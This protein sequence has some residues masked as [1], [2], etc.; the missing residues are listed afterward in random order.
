MRGLL[1]WNIFRRSVIPIGS[2]AGLLSTTC[3][4][5]EYKVG[6][7]NVRFW[8]LSRL[9]A[10]SHGNIVELLNAEFKIRAT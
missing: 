3:V 10:D 8:Y 9:V 5:F 6:I 2:V 4:C 1:L 7:R